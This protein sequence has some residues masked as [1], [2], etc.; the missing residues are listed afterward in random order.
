MRAE[1]PSVSN[2]QLKTFLLENWER[3]SLGKEWAIFSTPEESEAGD[4]YPTD[5]GRI[6][7]LA[8]HKTQPRFLVIE[9]KRGQSTDQTVGQVMRYIG[10]VKKNLAKDRQ[11]VEGLIIAHKVEET[12]RYAIS[13]LPN[14]K[15]MKYEVE[16]R[17]NECQAGSE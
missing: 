11:S 12:A 14:V 17:L 16:F 10:W 5:V 4:E 8:V 6:D 15:M 1:N 2:G 13:T 3:I 7:I 9:L